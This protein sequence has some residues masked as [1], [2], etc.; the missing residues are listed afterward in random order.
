[1]KGTL[2]RTLCYYKT[3]KTNL[4]YFNVAV[5]QYKR[6]LLTLILLWWST[7]WFRTF[8]RTGQQISLIIKYV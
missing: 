3:L 6:H 2:K 7:I 1:M 8:F 5:G 4:H